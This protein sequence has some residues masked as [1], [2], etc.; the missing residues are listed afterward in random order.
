MEC[1]ALFCD[2]TASITLNV[3]FVLYHIMLCTLQHLPPPL[4][5]STP[6]K[7]WISCVT[8]Q[9]HKTFCRESKSYSANS[10]LVFI[11]SSLMVLH[12][13][14]AKPLAQ[15]FCPLGISSSQSSIPQNPPINCKV[16]SQCTR[17][18]QVLF[19][20]WLDR[21]HLRCLLR[22]FPFPGIVLP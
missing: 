5:L 9:Q 22:S 8:T 21:S 1:T 17:R 11:I 3:P 18:G 20:C 15:P 14:I 19:D 16:L 2:I 4:L 12:S 13:G 7:L 10:D 6:I